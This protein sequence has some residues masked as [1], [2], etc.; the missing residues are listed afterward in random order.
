MWKDNDVAGSFLQPLRDASKRFRTA[1]EPGNE[2]A[3]DKTESG[4]A[5]LDLLDN[6]IERVTRSVGFLNES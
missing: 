4:V 6:V 1:M 5:E 2:L 3:E